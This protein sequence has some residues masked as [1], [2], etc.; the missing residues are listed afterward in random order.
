MCDTMSFERW[1]RESVVCVRDSEFMC[2]GE[3]VQV[4]ERVF[5]CIYISR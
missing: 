4:C 3:C 2:G 5:V 1:G